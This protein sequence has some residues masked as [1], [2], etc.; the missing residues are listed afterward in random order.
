MKKIFLTILIAITA[1]ALY[2][3]YFKPKAQNNLNIMKENTM[4]ERT[5]AIIKPDAVSAKNSGKIINRIEAEDFNIL[6]LQKIFLTKEQAE[7]F[8]DVHKGKAFFDE[9]IDFMTSGPVIIMVL[10]KDNAIKSWRDL[11]GATDP[12]QAEPNSIRKL[13]GTSKGKN[14]THGSDAPETAQREIAFFFPSI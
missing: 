2:F 6:A 1:I 14:A 12:A 8:Y 7:N 13:F 5:F 10:E 11:M 4:I 9:L 3:V